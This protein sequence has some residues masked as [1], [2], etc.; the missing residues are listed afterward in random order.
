LENLLLARL[1]QL[2]AEL[3]FLGGKGV[4]PSPGATQFRWGTGID[5]RPP[6]DP[7]GR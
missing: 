4:L 3:A 6:R 5:R 1:P 2:C 7:D